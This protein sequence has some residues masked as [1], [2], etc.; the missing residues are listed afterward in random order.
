MR[1]ALEMH[2]AGQAR[3]IP[4]LLRPVDW[5]N[6]PFG[7]LQ[8]LPKDAKPVT[9][10]RNR[11]EAWQDVAKG[12]RRAIDEWR[13]KRRSSDFSN[14]GGNRSI[15]QY[16]SP[17]DEFVTPEGFPVASGKV[18]GPPFD[19]VLLTTAEPFI[20][21]TAEAERLLDRFSSPTPNVA[22]I[23]GLAGIGKTALAA[24]VV[25]QLREAGAFPDGI[26]V[27]S[28][29]EETDALALASVALS[30]FDPYRRKPQVPDLASLAEE[31]RELLG[32]KRTLIIF[33]GLR[34]ETDLR[35]VVPL[36]H[37]CGS[38]LLLISQQMLPTDVIPADAREIL[39]P[40]T[41][42]EATELFMRAA[43]RS[44][45]EKAG[46][47]IDANTVIEE[48]V[49]ALGQHPL[50]IRLVAGYAADL[51][52][53]L[54][55]LA[56]DLR[57]PQGALAALWSN[58]SGILTSIL[59]E[60]YSTPPPDARRLYAA[61]PAFGTTDVGRRALEALAASL[62]M[63]EPEQVLNTLVVRTLLKPQLN[64]RMP[65]GS[66]RQRLRMHALRRVRKP[67]YAGE[68]E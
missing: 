59:D 49:S 7:R 34:P 41:L 58:Q 17:P 56:A 43:G 2:D 8:A 24:Q 31:A 6:A 44:I 37:R 4:I 27:V 11:D 42:A 48:I 39:D 60:A 65:A 29:R 10:W 46:I 19:D 15:S 51:Q 18:H 61:L 38:S 40:L 9:S 3:V 16:L 14:A 1:R 21:R 5:T 35:Q 33:D 32:G 22:A 68:Y 62:N 53:D 47:S 12:I 50:A 13:S 63:S 57:N 54:V 66:D 20:G 28:C 64:D 30:R 52:L 36:L 26:A 23:H 67:A 45:G 55:S 25:R